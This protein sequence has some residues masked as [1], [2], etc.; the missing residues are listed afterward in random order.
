MSYEI[1][2]FLAIGAAGISFIVGCAVGAN[3][4]QSLIER[5]AI[6]AGV[7][8]YTNNVSGELVFKWK[9]CK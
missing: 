3:G 5:N 7:A 8:Y 1:K 2:V 9:E 6:Q 4:T